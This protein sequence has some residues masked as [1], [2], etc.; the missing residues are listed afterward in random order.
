M[1]QVKHQ[2]RL[3][4][5][6]TTAIVSL[7]VV[8]LLTIGNL[9]TFRTTLRSQ[10]FVKLIIT[11][12][13]E[14]AAAM[15]APPSEIYVSKE[16]L[17]IKALDGSNWIVPKSKPRFHVLDEP[18]R[19]SREGISDYIMGRQRFQLVAMW[20]DLDSDTDFV[21]PIYCTVN[22]SKIDIDHVGPK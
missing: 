20:K 17:S 4:L 9:W 6:R 11:H 10:G 14:D 7:I 16:K 12:K 19:P 13:L 1:N 8:V 21:L 5:W 18:G 15:L 3:P 2:K 22:G